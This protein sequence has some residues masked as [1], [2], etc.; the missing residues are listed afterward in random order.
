[1]SEENSEKDIIENQDIPREYGTLVKN[2]FFSFLNTYGTFILSIISSFLLARLISDTPWGYFILGLSYI[3][4]VSLITK[5]LPPSLNNALK[6]YIP[7]FNSL[8]EKNRLKSF[9]LRAIYAKLTFLIPIFI[10][11]ILFFSLFSK[12]FLINL[13]EENMNIVLLLS[14]LIIINN[15][16]VILN[17]I[18]I[19]FNRFKTV[20]ISFLTQYLIYIA[21]L[22]YF[23][24]FFQGIDLEA[25]AF[26]YVIAA[27]IPFLMN[28]IIIIRN[29]HKIKVSGKSTTSLKDD[30]QDMVKYGSLVRAATFFTEIWAEIQIQSIGVFRPESVF[31]FKISRDLLSVSANASSA[32]AVPLT[33]SFT[34]FIAKEKKKNIVAIYNLIIK[35]LIFL[36]EILTGLLFFFTDF[37]IAFIYGEPRLIY[38]DIVKLY[39]FTSVFLIVS[40]PIVSL[41]LAENKGKYLVLVRFI[42]F[43]LQFPLFLVLLIYIN[44]YYA[45]FGI[46]ISNFL[47]SALYLFVTIKIGKI[48]LNIKRILFHYL[49]FFFSLGVTVI[50]EY[51]LLDNLNNLLLLSLNPSLFSVFNPFSL[52]VFV[53]VFM[54]LVIEFRVLT[55]GDI[56]NLQSFFFK[57]SIMHKIT[58]RALNFL[59]KILKE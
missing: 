34:S 52:L 3:Q 36:I 48:K 15:L 20:F 26:I 51:F 25:L 30:F 44:L 10:I 32:V 41:L 18:N 21:F 16:Q 40:G 49:I 23:F 42:G 55:V 13:P 27:L 37:F 19:G 45:I 33:I 7:R 38:S 50:L 46:I 57:K 47:F 43:L 1:M 59:K 24:I 22:L 31:G 2:S 58:N 17:S 53:L 4:I 5:L 56:N 11:A 14:P 28:I 12:I 29:I 8:N 54:F 35:Y 39:L 9:I 6:Y